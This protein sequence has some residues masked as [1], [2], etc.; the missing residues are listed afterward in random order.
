M[1]IL[2]TGIAGQLG[3]R[4]SEILKCYGIDHVGI[5]RTKTYNTDVPYLCADL[6]DLTLNQIAEFAK[7][8]THVIHF[9]DVIDDS[10]DF[11]NKLEGQFHNCCI[12]TIKL[13]EAL[14]NIKHFSF[15]SSVAVYGTPLELP[16][17]ENTTPSPQ[18]IYG[19]TKL[20]TEQY[21]NLIRTKKELPISILRIGSIY[22]P[23][24]KNINQYR[25]VP[26]IINT[27]L[28]NKDPY[29]VKSG[30]TYRDY[31]YIDDCVNATINATLLSMDGV[32]NIASGVGTSIKTIAE[33]I[34]NISN[35]PLNISYRH[36]LPEEWSA[37]CNIDKM[38]NLLNYTPKFSL[39]EGLQ[40]TFEWHE[41]YNNINT[42]A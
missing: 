8:V 23:G 14:P 26:N 40:L 29:V 38:I 11:I 5:S 7:D 2:I 17:T 15:A 28:K 16:I 10:I 34:I 13:I 18:N 39:Y 20:M 12:N 33:T 19:L 25:A 37:V 31:M 27:V 9:A 42:S 36:D 35:K 24:P 41:K 3:N 32:F 22:G 4:I 6:S 21:L 30:N 1:K